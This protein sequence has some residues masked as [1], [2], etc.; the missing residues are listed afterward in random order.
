V[1]QQAKRIDCENVSDISKLSTQNPGLSY[2]VLIEL[3]RSDF[4]VRKPEHTSW[5]YKRPAAMPAARS[6]TNK[7]HETHMPVQE[8]RS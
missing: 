2:D 5:R 8:D 4:I 1:S 7:R 3:Q 6:A